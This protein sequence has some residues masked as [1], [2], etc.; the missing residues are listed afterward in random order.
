M[1]RTST[2]SSLLDSTRS[3]SGPPRRPVDGNLDAYWRALSEASGSST[4]RRMACLGALT[5]VPLPG[6]LLHRAREG[7]LE[8]DQLRPRRGDHDPDHAVIKRRTSASH[9]TRCSGVIV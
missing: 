2:V 5:L 7:G 6:Q 3:I 4:L 8:V 9:S 1:D